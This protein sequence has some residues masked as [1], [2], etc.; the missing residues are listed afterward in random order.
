ME[1]FNFLNKFDNHQ[2][3]YCKYQHNPKYSVSEKPVYEY[4]S[5]DECYSVK[6]FKKEKTFEIQVKTEEYSYELIMDNVS[7]IKMFHLK[8][9]DVVIR[10]AKAIKAIKDDFGKYYERNYLRFSYD[11]GCNSTQIESALMNE[12]SVARLIDTFI[13]INNHDGNYRDP[14]ICMAY[15]MD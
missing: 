4:Y 7:S 1:N 11:D 3:D 6:F 12:I 2:S 13:S 5:V 15:N 8:Y 14:V 10:V 9:K